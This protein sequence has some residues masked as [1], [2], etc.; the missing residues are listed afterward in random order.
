MNYN[1][2]TGTIMLS[3]LAASIAGFVLICVNNRRRRQGHWWWALLA[4]LLMTPGILLL[5]LAALAAGF[6]DLTLCFVFLLFCPSFILLGLWASKLPRSRR[7][8]PMLISVILATI[9]VFSAEY[10][11]YSFSRSTVLLS[12]AKAVYLNDRVEEGLPATLAELE[13]MCRMHPVFLP[14]HGFADF[15]DRRPTDPKPLYLQTNTAGCIYAVEPAT[16]R[17][18][19]MDRR[20]LILGRT[21]AYPASAEELQR[22]LAE[23]DRRRA[24]AGE[25]GRWSEVDWQTER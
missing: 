8:G 15:A 9:L 4:I 6:G 3:L 18:R 1:T 10:I 5:E 11:I 14:R 7:L 16:F 2:I 13:E 12:M 22:L 21:G 24:E 19:G 23:D 17:N 20:Y 25:T